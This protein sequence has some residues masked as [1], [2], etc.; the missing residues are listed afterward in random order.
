MKLK[1]TKK[2]KAL[3]LDIPKDQCET[4]R[5]INRKTKKTKLKIKDIVGY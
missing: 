2:T 3:G 5:E 1:I 4:I